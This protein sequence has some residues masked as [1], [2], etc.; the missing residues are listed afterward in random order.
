[1]R[2]CG[3][4]WSRAGGASLG[5]VD[6]WVNFYLWV[7]PNASASARY[8]ATAYPQP[9]AVYQARRGRARRR[10]GLLRGALTGAMRS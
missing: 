1:V 9:N 3:S 5:R 2:A 10:E 8:K 7:S 6:P 4:E